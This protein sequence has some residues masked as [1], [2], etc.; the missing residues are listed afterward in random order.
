S[1]SQLDQ[2]LLK[3]HS[4]N[5]V[6]SANRLPQDILQLFASSMAVGGSSNAGCNFTS[7]SSLP[8]TNNTESSFIC[9]N[10]TDNDH[11]N[12]IARNNKANIA[13]VDGEF[14]LAKPYELSQSSSSTIAT[15][16]V[17]TT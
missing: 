15:L 4:T 3:S 13:T 1:S 9:A 10:F 6:A 16:T 5:L 8:S 14:L 11:V 12:S 7:S 2:T 17:T